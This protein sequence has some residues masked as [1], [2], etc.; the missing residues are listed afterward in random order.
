MAPVP[1]SEIPY[2]LE[3]LLRSL[4]DARLPRGGEHTQRTWAIWVVVALSFFVRSTVVIWPQA[5]QVSITWPSPSVPNACLAP[6]RHRGSRS[7][8][9]GA[10]RPLAISP[11]CP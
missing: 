1:L 2:T 3:V 7:G 4:S 11:A 5:V 10:R 8:V 9:G 6:H